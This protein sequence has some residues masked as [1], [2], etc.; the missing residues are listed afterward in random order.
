MARC[1][2]LYGTVRYVFFVMVPYWLVS[3]MVQ[4]DA[5]YSDGSSV[6]FGLK[7][8]AVLY[9]TVWSG[10]TGYLI[11]YGTVRYWLK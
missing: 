7:Y 1:C 11:W 6:R 2:F 4:Y 8:R 5:G 9:G 10:D 3:V